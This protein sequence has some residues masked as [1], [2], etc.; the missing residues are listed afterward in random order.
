[1]VQ[2]DAIG[3]GMVSVKVSI[4]QGRRVGA[5]PLSWVK[6]WSYP[7]SAPYALC[8]FHYFIRYIWAQNSCL[9][10]AQPHL[11]LIF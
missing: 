11:K 2:K 5:C 6:M 4:P 7:G 10:L 3:W 9:C 8:T 1:M